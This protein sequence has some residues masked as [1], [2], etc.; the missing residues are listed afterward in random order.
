MFSDSFS[1]CHISVNHFIN[2]GDCQI[3][4]LLLCLNCQDLIS[5]KYLFEFI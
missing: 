1:K 5:Y 4:N 2:K 3:L